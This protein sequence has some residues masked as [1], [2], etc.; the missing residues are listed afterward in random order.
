MPEIKSET[1]QYPRDKIDQKPRLMTNI[2][3]NNLMKSSLIEQ[4]N[5]DSINQNT[6]RYRPE[7]S[8]VIS[9]KMPVICQKEMEREL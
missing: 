3:D 4:L 7:K 1:N 5:N 9:D 8:A 2:K 6:K